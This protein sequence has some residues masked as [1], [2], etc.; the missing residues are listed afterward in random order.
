[1]ISVCMAS[2]NGEKYIEEQIRSILQ[3][4]GEDD[5]LIVSDDGSSDNTLSIISGIKDSRIVV[6]YNNQ[7]CYTK[8]FENAISHAKGDYI[9]LSDQDDVWLPDKV[10]TTIAAFEKT[11]ADFIVSSATAV[12]KDKNVLLKSTFDVGA[13]KTGF[14]YNLMKT[15]Y[16]GACMAFKKEVLQRVLPIPGKDK[17]IAHDYWIACICE[18]YYKTALID[19]PLILYRRHGENTSPALG[20]SKL[21][22][23]ERVYKRFYAMYYICRRQ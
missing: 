5:E 11:G 16:I 4:I 7:G 18:R 1:M 12:D 2:Y 6:L 22:I 3:Q 19:K 15:S 23:A 9:F 14:W 17:Y 20:K 21:S 8:N 10:T 13:T